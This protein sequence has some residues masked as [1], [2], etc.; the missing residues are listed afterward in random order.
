MLHLA[1][2]SYAEAAD[3]VRRWHYSANMPQGGRAKYR[4]GVWEDEQFIGAVVYGASPSPSC[5]KSIGLGRN[6]VLELVRVALDT[7]RTPTTRIVAVANRLLA[8]EVPGLR[9]LVSYADTAQGHDGTIYR[10]GNWLYAGSVVKE[11][12]RVNGKPVHRRVL[13]HRYGTSSLLWL[14]QNVDPAAE[15]VRTPPKHRYL[16]PLDPEIRQRIAPLIRP[17][18]SVA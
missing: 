5:G 11:P 3:A 9:L 7:H 1:P 16:Y 14:R 15:L 13:N 12:I 17:F 10:A 8:A 2:I 4:Y 6:E 18:A